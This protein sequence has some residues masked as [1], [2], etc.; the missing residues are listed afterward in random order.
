MT[1]GLQSSDKPTSDNL[2]PQETTKQDALPPRTSH[3]HSHEQIRTDIGLDSTYPLLYGYGICSMQEVRRL[4]SSRD[5]DRRA[6]RTHRRAICLHQLR[7]AMVF[8]MC[9]G[10]TDGCRRLIKNFSQGSDTTASFRISVIGDG[11]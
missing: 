3:C 5:S 6:D 1:C 7:T 9:E 2:T 8:R 4:T 11:H 10:A